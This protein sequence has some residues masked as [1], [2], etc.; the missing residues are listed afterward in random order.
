MHPKRFHFF[1]L[2]LIFLLS[3]EK[4]DICIPET[5]DSPKM[6]VL[7]RSFEN[8]E[9]RKV[10][11]DFKI[12]AIGNETPITASSDSIVLAL[13]PEKEFTQ[14]EFIT[15]FEKE[16][17]NIDTLQINYR[18]ADIFISSACGYRHNFIFESPAVTQLNPGSDWIFGFTVLKD[19]IS[20]EQQGHL[21]LLH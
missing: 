9:I 11:N 20:D 2:V 14:F 12:R 1:T 4:D 10:P 18:R 3:C 5:Q 16:I 13:N 15:D 19:T 6:I 8:P 17:E 21:A 7:M